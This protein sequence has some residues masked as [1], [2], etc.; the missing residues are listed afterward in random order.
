MPLASIL[1]AIQLAKEAVEAYNQIKD[2]LS[3]TD[4]AEV[5]SALAELQ[6][7]NDALFARLD[8]KLGKAL[9]D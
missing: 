7:K 4:Q 8:G 3:S 6:A 1:S 2:T 9:K 5:E